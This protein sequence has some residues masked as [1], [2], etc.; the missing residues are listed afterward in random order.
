MSQL[1]K[2]APYL[3]KLILGDNLEKFR[4]DLN[5]MYINFDLKGLMQRNIQKQTHS[6]NFIS[7][8]VPS[9]NLNFNL[10]IKLNLNLIQNL[11]NSKILQCC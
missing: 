4:E 8:D 1:C 9:L 11:S 7:T 10:I 3:N 2:I 6:L 5:M